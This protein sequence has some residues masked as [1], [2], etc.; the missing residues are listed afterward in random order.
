M[1]STVTK[2]YEIYEYCSLIPGTRNCTLLY[3]KLRYD[4]SMKEKVSLANM[5]IGCWVCEENWW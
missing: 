5:K 4:V 3:A 1:P 2:R